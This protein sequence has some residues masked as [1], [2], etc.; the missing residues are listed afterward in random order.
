MFLDFLEKPLQ[1]EEKLKVAEISEFESK[2]GRYVKELRILSTNS[3]SPQ[4]QVFNGQLSGVHHLF[5]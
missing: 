3:P 1:K 2:L 5:F 4:K